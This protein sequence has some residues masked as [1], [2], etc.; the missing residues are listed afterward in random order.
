MRKCV[1]ANEELIRESFGA[2]VG[3]LHKTRR[4]FELLRHRAEVLRAFRGV[5]FFF[6]VWKTQGLEEVRLRSH[7]P[8]RARS[9]ATVVEAPAGRSPGCSEF[10]AQV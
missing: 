9:A 2:W 5:G 8:A 6:L 1:A 4:I 10:P 3:L 7:H